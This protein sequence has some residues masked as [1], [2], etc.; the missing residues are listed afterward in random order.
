MSHAPDTHSATSATS[1]ASRT[2]GMSRNVSTNAALASQCG[3]SRMTLPKTPGMSASVAAVICPITAQS[4]RD[5]G[6][7]ASRPIAITSYQGSW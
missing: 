2:V 1:A 6:Y 5:A 3:R 4:S 7:T